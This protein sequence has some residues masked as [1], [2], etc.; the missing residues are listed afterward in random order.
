VI[1]SSKVGASFRRRTLQPLASNDSLDGCV[2]VL[3]VIDYLNHG[4]YW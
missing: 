1:Y 4:S 3:L 2:V